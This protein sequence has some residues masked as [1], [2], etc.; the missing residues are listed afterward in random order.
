MC[1][2]NNNKILIPFQKSEEIMS[3]LPKTPQIISIN[4]H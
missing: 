3:K 1:N 4:K 2:T